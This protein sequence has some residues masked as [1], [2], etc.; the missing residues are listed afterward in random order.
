MINLPNILSN[1]PDSEAYDDYAHQPWIVTNEEK[2][3]AIVAKIKNKPVQGNLMIAVSCFFSLNVFSIRKNLEYLLI[4]DRGV[5]VHHFWLETKK[6][7]EE[8]ADRLE[9]YEKVKVVAL[10]NHKKYYSGGPFSS[11]VTVTSRLS[12]LDEEVKSGV[13]WLSDK[14][15][16]DRVR[17]LLLSNRFVIKQIDLCNSETVKNLNTVLKANDLSLDILYL[18]NVR[19]FVF[20]DQKLTP[21]HRGLDSLLTA[22]AYLIDAH[23]PSANKQVRQRITQRGAKSIS[24]ALA[25]P[26]RAK[27]FPR[28]KP[29]SGNGCVI[30]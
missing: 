18:S 14:E 20:D 28:K 12:H 3:G 23:S 4:L 5:R 21:F 9:A 2:A 29:Q 25:S 30:S 8:T 27:Q 17:S 26:Y 22:K 11:S 16:Y 6:I 1:I 24:A 19:R 7:V 10:A 13:S 15:R